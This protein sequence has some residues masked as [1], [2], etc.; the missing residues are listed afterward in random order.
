MELN[1]TRQST[2]W[3][4]PCS[5]LRQSFTH[6][7]PDEKRKTVKTALVRLCVDY[8]FKPHVPPLSTNSRQFC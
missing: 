1:P 2:S 6:L 7:H 5:T 4:Q 3:R 8:R